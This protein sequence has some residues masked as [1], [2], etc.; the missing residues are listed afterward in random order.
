ML[1]LKCPVSLLDMGRNHDAKVYLLHFKLGFTRIAAPCRSRSCRHMQCFEATTFLSMNEQTPTWSCPVCNRKINSIQDLVIDGYFDDILSTVGE[2]VHSVRIDP[3]GQLQL[4]EDNN[5]DAR[6]LETS[7]RDTNDSAVIILD[8]DDDEVDTTTTQEPGIG[9]KRPHDDDVAIEST[10]T[11]QKTDVHP[12]VIDL[13]LSDDEEEVDAAQG[14]Q[15]QQTPLTAM[16]P[17]SS[18]SA[19]QHLVTLH[20][21]APGTAI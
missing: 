8:D 17:P 18:S 5:T 12:Q 1:S 15:Q 10:T 13:T 7:L 2:D 3:D 4:L 6:S 16:P 21:P 14:Q 20:L 9:D 19:T 11:R